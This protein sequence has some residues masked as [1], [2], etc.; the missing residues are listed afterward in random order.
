M[1]VIDTSTARVTTLAGTGMA[2]LRDAALLEAHFSEPAG[3]AFGRNQRT[4]L[5]ADTNNNAIRSAMLELR[6]A[7]MDISCLCQTP[8]T[9]RSGG[10]RAP[11]A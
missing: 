8:P 9:M 7:A 6:F 3:L 5:V 2:G 11:L 1:Q 4:L 10:A